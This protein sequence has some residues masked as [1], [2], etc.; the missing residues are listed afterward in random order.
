[1]RPSSWILVFVSFF[2]CQAHFFVALHLQSA[3]CSFNCIGVTHLTMKCANPTCSKGS[4]HVFHSSRALSMHILKNDSCRL[5]QE[6]HNL[7]VQAQSSHNSNTSSSLT[8]SR[9]RGTADTT[10]DAD[11]V[12]LSDPLPEHFT[13]GDNSVVIDDRPTKRYKSHFVTTARQSAIVK[14]VMLL[15]DMNCPDYALQNI[16]QWVVEA[17][18]ERIS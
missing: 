8:C 16:L 7:V 5:Y 14:L 13:Q 15:D 11:V 9:P 17:Q 12:A 1:M 6:H 2:I 10:F 4:H 3:F 18:R